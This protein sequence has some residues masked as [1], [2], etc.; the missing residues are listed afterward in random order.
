MT[1][2]LT[3]I[4][5]IWALVKLKINKIGRPRNVR[6]LNDQKCLKKKSQTKLPSIKLFIKQNRELGEMNISI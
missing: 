1:I 2:E 4:V 6:L 5:P 3:E